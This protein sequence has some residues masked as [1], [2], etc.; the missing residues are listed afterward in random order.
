MYFNF[1]SGGIKESVPPVHLQHYSLNLT[2][3][4]FIEYQTP[5]QTDTRSSLGAVVDSNFVAVSS[6][7]KTKKKH[8]TVQ[9]E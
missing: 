4:F 6:K 9:Q 2:D 3:D 8:A 5:T 1:Y 7:K